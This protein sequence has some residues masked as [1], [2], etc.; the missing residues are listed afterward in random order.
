MTQKNEDQTLP[1]TFT[2][3]HPEKWVKVADLK[4][5]IRVRTIDRAYVRTFYNKR[6]QTHQAAAVL[7]FGGR[8]HLILNMTQG[9]KIFELTGIDH[10][11]SLKGWTITMAP[12]Q[13]SGKATIVIQAARPP[14]TQKAPTA[15]PEGPEPDNGYLF[16]EIGNGFPT[17]VPANLAPGAPL[18][19]PGSEGDV[20]F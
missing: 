1:Q 11:P 16:D 10:I 15:V 17:A 19:G 9:L 4:G 18:V 8:K 5:E 12:G 3:L 13:Q 2:S 14:D 7:D 6:E 20:R